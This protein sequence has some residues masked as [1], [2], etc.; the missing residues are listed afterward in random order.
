VRARSRLTFRPLRRLP[1]STQSAARDASVASP[2]LVVFMAFG[3]VVL[4]LAG[5]AADRRRRVGQ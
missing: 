2:G 4:V 3:L 5:A 1:R